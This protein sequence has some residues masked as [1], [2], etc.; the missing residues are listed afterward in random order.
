MRKAYKIKRSFPKTLKGAG[1]KVVSEISSMQ[2]AIAKG[3]MIAPQI[4]QTTQTTQT[5]QPT[6]ENT[7]RRSADTSMD[8]FRKMAK[9]IKK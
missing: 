7:V 4:T 5:S 9:D 2:K 8:M 6:Q 3:E 1:A